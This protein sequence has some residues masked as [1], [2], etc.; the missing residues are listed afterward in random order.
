MT[1]TPRLLQGHP[2]HDRSEQKA[3]GTSGRE[4]PDLNPRLGEEATPLRLNVQTTESQDPSFLEVEC[5]KASDSAGGRTSPRQH[6]AP[7]AGTSSGR[8]LPAHMCGVGK[9]ATPPRAEC[10]DPSMGGC[11]LSRGGTHKGSGLGP[12]PRA[13]STYGRPRQ[14]RTRSCIL[15]AANTAG[16][17]CE[18]DCAGWRRGR[19]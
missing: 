16:A 8:G 4:S 10:S 18:S 13:H 12:Y 19:Q 5:T 6:D 11:M 17:W 15:T 2:H 7:E 3:D 9:G 14:S 1:T